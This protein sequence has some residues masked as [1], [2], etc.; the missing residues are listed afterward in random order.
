MRTV[1]VCSAIKHARTAKCLYTILNNQHVPEFDLSCQLP[2]GIVSPEKSVKN[3]TEVTLKKNSSFSVYYCC[4][5][6][7]I[8]IRVGHLFL[9]DHETAMLIE[10][11]SFFVRPFQPHK[12]HIMQH[13]KKHS[14]FIAEN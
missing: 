13:M 2:L 11:F 7:Y 14:V 3:F 6:D 5:Y 9:T 8:P 12:G 4:L 1:S 10:L